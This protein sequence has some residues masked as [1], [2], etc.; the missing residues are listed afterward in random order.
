MKKIL[1]SSLILGVLFGIAAVGAVGLVGT[2]VQAA[3]NI[4]KVDVFVSFD[5]MPIN[6]ELPIASA[7]GANP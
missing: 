3:E 1:S 2:N 5:K 6:L 7:P 4:S